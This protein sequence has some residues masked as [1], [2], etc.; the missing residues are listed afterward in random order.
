[1]ND[2]FNMKYVRESIDLFFNKA[3]IEH[4][5]NSSQQVINQDLDP[6]QFKE[7][8]VSHHAVFIIPKFLSVFPFSKAYYM[9]IE[10][11]LEII[12]G[13]SQF[14]KYFTEFYGRTQYQTEKAILYLLILTLANISLI[15]GEYNDRMK[16]KLMQIEKEFLSQINKVKVKLDFAGFESGHLENNFLVPFCRDL[17]NIFKYSAVSFY[18]ENLAKRAELNILRSHVAESAKRQKE[19]AAA[20]EKA[21]KEIKV[22]AD[23]VNRM[24]MEENLLHPVERS[25]LPTTNSEDT[26]NQFALRAQKEPNNANQNKD[27]RNSNIMR[28]EESVKDRKTLFFQNFIKDNKSNNKLK[29]PDAVQEFDI[30]PKRRNAES[31]KNKAIQ[32]VTNKLS[33]VPKG[34]QTKTRMIKSAYTDKYV[35]KKKPTEEQCVVNLRN[36][37]DNF[38]KLYND[39]MTSDGR[40]E[41]GCPK[42]LENS[43]TTK[44][45]TVTEEDTGFVYNFDEN[46]QSIQFADLCNEIQMA[47]TPVKSGLNNFNSA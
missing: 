40:I 47:K 8:S 43:E 39:V 11:L 23:N 27:L 38:T 14:T 13:E 25:K 7:F 36:M 37:S 1:M 3:I 24:L 15:K 17:L 9:V 41:P 32:K 16:Q 21:E 18:F 20:K 30:N 26:N 28:S 6:E 29:N 45:Q 34:K 5:I 19:G 2:R 22:R 46:Q 33:L 31:K 35:T 44:Q 10:Q 4:S 12:E 42:N